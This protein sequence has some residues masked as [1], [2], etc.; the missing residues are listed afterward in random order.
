[1]ALLNKLRKGTV[2]ALLTTILV[3]TQGC[4]YAPASLSEKTSIPVDASASAA[5]NSAPGKR[6][7][8]SLEYIT[9]AENTLYNDGGEGLPENKRGYKCMLA[10]LGIEKE[11]LEELVKRGKEGQ[12]LGYDAFVKAVLNFP[13]ELKTEIIFGTG[14]TWGEMYNG[15]IKKAQMKEKFIATARRFQQFN[16][17]FSDKDIEILARLLDKNLE[18]EY[19]AGSIMLI[20]TSPDSASIETKTNTGKVDPKSLENTRKNTE[21]ETRVAVITDEEKDVFLRYYDNAL[22]IVDQTEWGLRNPDK[23]PESSLERMYRT[24]YLPRV[25]GK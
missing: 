24:F 22:K 21:Y 7:K 15:S 23:N 3:Q 20:K 25:K 16:L 4:T 5:E 8:E 1:M 2:A 6:K 19:S 14:N 9:I 13:R 11:S 18:G 12:A 10:T 17:P